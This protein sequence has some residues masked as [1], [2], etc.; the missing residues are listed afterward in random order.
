MKKVLFAAVMML[1][2]VGVAGVSPLLVEAYQEGQ[3]H[4]PED[5]SDEA[6]VATVSFSVDSVCYVLFAIGGLAQSVR[7]W[8]E[9]DGDSLPPVIYEYDADARSFVN[10]TYISLLDPGEHT[11]LLRLSSYLNSHNPATCKNGYLQALIFLP[12]EPGA[13]A[14]PPGDNHQPQAMRSVVSQGPYV[15]VAGASE[16]VD[17]TGRVIEG[18]IEEDKVYLSNL[19]T[20]I[21]FARNGERTVVKIVKVE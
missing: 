2:S 8:L 16:L 18:A 7:V 11:V 1:V 5:E 17:A 12:D 4:I 20:G 10:L 9:L 6:T 14:E 3:I 19:P 15:N 21:Y 13:I